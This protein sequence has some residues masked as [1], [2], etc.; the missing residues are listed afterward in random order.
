MNVVVD[1]GVVLGVNRQPTS[2][3]K[4]SHAQKR[5][6]P[7]RL[8]I[9]IDNPLAPKV[10]RQPHDTKEPAQCPCSWGMW[11]ERFAGSTQSSPA[12]GSP[13]RGFSPLP[14]RPTQQPLLHRPGLTPRTSS[15][16]ALVGSEDNLPASARIPNG[17]NL[18]QELST[19]PLNND[20]LVVLTAIIGIHKEHDEEPQVVDIDFRGQSLQEFAGAGYKAVDVAGNFEQEKVRFQDLHQSIA[21]CDLVLGEVEEYMASFK[22]D[23]AAVSTEIESLQQRSSSLNAKLDNRKVVETLL[24]PEADALSISPAVVRKL[25]AGPIDDTWVRA[26]DK[27]QKRIRSIETKL[28]DGSSMRAAQDLKPIIEDVSNKAVERIRDHVVTQIKALRAPHINVQNIQ[29]NQLLRI[30]S[31]YAFLATRQPQLAQD[32]E[33]AYVN[34]MRWYYSSSFL[35]YKSAVEQLK[36]HEIESTETI[37]ETSRR[38]MKAVPLHDAFS[39]GRR[40]DVV[41]AGGAALSSYVAEESK[42]TYYLEIPFR[43]FNLAIVDNAS[44]EYSFMSEFFS[45]Q[46]SNTTRRFVEIWQP[47]MEL[48]QAFTRALIEHNQDAIGVLICVRLNQKSAFELQRRK[49]P[50]AEGYTNAISMILW[51]RFQLI[52]DAHCES[53]RKLTAS[54]PGKPTSSA[55]SLAAS[56]NAIPDTAPHP[57]TQ[58]I[59]NFAHAI[60]ALSSEAGDDEP[61]ANS[62]RRL[63]SVYEAFLLRFSKGAA[64]ARKRER[65]LHNNYSLFCTILADTPGRMATD[66]RSHFDELRNGLD[67]A[68]PSTDR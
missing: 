32:I 53:V 26:L 2:L 39:L 58:R 27:F 60:M 23:L 20:P 3:P 16:G 48:G 47:T 37:A 10:D 52:L 14:R 25:I 4:Q 41:K 57:L 22:A 12:G 18:R 31:G 66:I 42:D 29:Q 63:I 62:L 44:A 45:N 59:A 28:K 61:V 43:T 33:Q 15:L 34:T 8:R 46:S 49:I 67:V 24:G 5:P 11:L 13:S 21:G 55:L 19:V 6:L 9:F 68:A 17:S 50:A 65:L 35:R 38:P 1:A 36:V 64:D 40:M 54:L 30:K 7:P 51:P 56:S